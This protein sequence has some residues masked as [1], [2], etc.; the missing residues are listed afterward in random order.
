MKALW[1]K[2][3]QSNQRR[4][5]ALKVQERQLRREEVHFQQKESEKDDHFMRELQAAEDRL[6]YND[7]STMQE[8]LAHM[9][10]HVRDTI[11]STVANRREHLED[12]GLPINNNQAAVVASVLEG[13]RAGRTKQIVT[14]PA[15]H[16]KSRI[17][18]ALI[19]ILCRHYNKRKFRVVFAHDQLLRSDKAAQR[20]VI[21]LLGGSTTV[22]YVCP[23]G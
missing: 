13:L 5:D 22:E 4:A 8:R 14:V 20:T 17:T 18:P 7:A 11:L 6:K 16:G 3:E 10:I 2:L 15:G 19:D 12:C 21:S 9:D 1:R 23:R